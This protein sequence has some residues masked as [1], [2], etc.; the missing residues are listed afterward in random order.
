MATAAERFGVV[1]VRAALFASNAA[2][3]FSQQLKKDFR[4]EEGKLK[5]VGE[6]AQ[7]LQDRLKKDGAMM[8]ESERARV[9]EEFEEKAKEF[10]YLKNKFEATVSKRKQKF[11]LE[12]KPKVDAAILKIAKANRVQILF[13]KEATLWVDGKFD[14][15]DQ[16][17]AELNR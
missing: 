7:K 13:P 1:D 4:G 15:T 3:S 2:K 12:S 9:A 11:L 17:I 14:L 16:V 8:S 6:Q 5:S 10:N